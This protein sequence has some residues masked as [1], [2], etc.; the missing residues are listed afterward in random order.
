MRKAANIL[1]IENA[2]FVAACIGCVIWG[3]ANFGIAIPVWL[4]TCSKVAS[5]SITVILT[6]FA[7]ITYFLPKWV[8]KRYAK[9]VFENKVRLGKHVIEFPAN[10]YK[11]AIRDGKLY[12]GICM[13]E[14]NFYRIDIKT[15]TVDW[16]ADINGEAVHDFVYVDKELFVKNRSSEVF[17]LDPESGAVQEQLED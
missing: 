3:M 13:Q 14:K 15:L 17:Q 6:I 11:I 16:Q 4:V 2:L 8:R 10:V 7:L 9:F 5:I 12:V 1:F